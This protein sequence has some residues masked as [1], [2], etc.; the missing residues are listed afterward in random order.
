MRVQCEKSIIF[1]CKIRF[2]YAIACTL[3][4]VRLLVF[5]HEIDAPCLASDVEAQ[6][7]PLLMAA[8][9]VINTNL[10]YCFTSYRNRPNMPLSKS[11]LYYSWY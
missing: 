10:A 3:T 4:N 1:W 11:L 9:L 7:H 8:Y 2:Y 5:L 6:G